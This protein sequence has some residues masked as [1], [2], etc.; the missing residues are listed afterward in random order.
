[1]GSV[2]EVRI[3]RASRILPLI[4]L[5]IL[6][7]FAIRNAADARRVADL[8]QWA[9]PEWLA[10]A[11]VFQVATYVS[12]GLGYV[13]LA[14]GVRVPL[15]LGAA[16]RMSVVNLFV[17]AAIP[18]AGLSGNLFLVRM[19]TRAG[20]PAGS[21]A[22]IVFGER[23]VYFTALVAFVGVLAG[24]RLWV[25]GGWST[26]ALALLAL[27]TLA[28]VLA[29]ALRALLRRPIAAIDWL[30]RAL[31]RAPAFIARRVSLDTLRE[32]ARRLEEAGGASAIGPLRIGAV[33]LCELAL[34]TFDAL[35]LWAMLRAIGSPAT[36]V[37]AAGAYG[38]ATAF[39]QT[40]LI[41]GGLEVGL[42]ALLTTF[43]VR[44]FASVAATLLFHVA[45][46]WV[47]LPFG[48]LFYRGARRQ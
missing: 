7:V 16:T 37:Q 46:V 34:L 27:G 32:D 47:A 41:P 36:L 4:L 11:L 6:A 22:V 17:N 38:L 12:V 14:R 39:A 20:I 26:E 13:L 28:V 8:L 1:M 18:T 30:S 48:W 5:A 25:Q 15:R 35:T 42:A 2:D 21:G 33:F 10:A 31:T 29:S 23:A 40:I 44:A 3:P 43:G 9:H 45:S 24:N 19:M